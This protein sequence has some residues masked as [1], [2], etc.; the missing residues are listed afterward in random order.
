MSA[1]FPCVSKTPIVPGI[2]DFPQFNYGDMEEIVAGGQGLVA[3][4]VTNI[5]TMPRPL[6]LLFIPYKFFIRM[7]IRFRIT[8]EK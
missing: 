2:I 1:K 3:Q 5:R 8:R 4:V 7:M 6:F